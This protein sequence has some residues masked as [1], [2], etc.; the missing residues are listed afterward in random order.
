MNGFPLI[1]YGLI[2]FVLLGFIIFHSLTS[3]V[4]DREREAFFLGR[5][6]NF[7]AKCSMT[8]ID[9]KYVTAESVSE[10]ENGGK[11]WKSENFEGF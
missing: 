10:D 11:R 8:Y 4:L 9:R 6:D 1:K 5:W 3:H 2:N 7:V